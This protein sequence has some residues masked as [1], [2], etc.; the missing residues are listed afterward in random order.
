MIEFESRIFAEAF[1]AKV[2]KWKKKFD[3]GSLFT[4]V[5]DIAQSPTAVE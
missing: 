2:R 4:D 5:I 3:V 1:L